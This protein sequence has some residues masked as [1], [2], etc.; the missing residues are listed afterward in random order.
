MQFATPNSGIGFPGALD[1][2]IQVSQV[3]LTFESVAANFV[4]AN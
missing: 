1:L 2:I 3:E 4:F